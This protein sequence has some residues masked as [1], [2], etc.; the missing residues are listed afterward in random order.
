MNTATSSAICWP[1]V[2]EARTDSV[3]DAVAWLYRSDCTLDQWVLWKP[4]HAVRT[5][6]MRHDEHSDELEHP[7]LAR[8]LSSSIGIQSAE[9]RRSKDVTARR[10]ID[11]ECVIATV[12]S[13]PRCWYTHDGVFPPPR[14]V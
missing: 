11:R 8:R 12:G 9:S 10:A 7:V 3:R 1:A 5:T 2:F 14:R 13:R 6:I 4:V